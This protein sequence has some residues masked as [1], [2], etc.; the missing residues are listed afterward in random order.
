M[1]LFQQLTLFLSLST[2]A[3]HSPVM[4]VAMCFS[5]L[6]CIAKITLFQCAAWCCSNGS[7]CFTV[8]GRAPLACDEFV[9]WWSLIQLHDKLGD[10]TRSTKMILT[11]FWWQKMVLWFCQ[12]RRKSTVALRSRE[13]DSC[14]CIHTCKYVYVNVYVFVYIHTHIYIYNAA[15]LV[16][17]E[18]VVLGCHR[19]NTSNDAIRD[20]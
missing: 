15:P 3:L 10:R 9:E 18:F 20:E 19:S 5:L 6:Q 1:I 16:Y 11:L 2:I 4:R 12:K 13:K 7:V 17:D 14:I 8:D